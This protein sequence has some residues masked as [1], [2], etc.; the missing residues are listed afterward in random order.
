[1]LAYCR[2]TINKERLTSFSILI[3]AVIWSVFAGLKT[4][5]T[6]LYGDMTHYDHIAIAILGHHVYS[7]WG[8]DPDAQITPGYPLFLS[9]CYLIANL[10]YPNHPFQLGITV[11]FQSILSGV[12]VYL[13]YQL[14][15]QCT[16][17]LLSAF[18]AL[19]YS[20]YPPSVFAP[21]MILTETLYTFLLLLFLYTFFIAIQKQ[22]MTRWLICGLT[23]GLCCT[24]RPS[25]FPFL[26]APM[27]Y[28]TY[29]WLNRRKRRTSRIKSTILH[30][31]A[32]AAGFIFPL[33]PWW[34]RNI[35]AFHQLILTDMDASNPLL[36]GTDPTFQA[37]SMLGSGLDSKGQMILA[38]HR[39]FYYFSNEFWTYLWWY[40]GEKLGLLF[41]TPW[42][43]LVA[44]G[45]YSGW[46][47][48]VLFCLHLHFPFV[49]LG[50][51]GLTLGINH[52]T[53]R[54]VSWFT[55]SLILLL[56]PFIPL[57]RYAFPT[58]PF[59]FIGTAY[60]VHWIYAQLFEIRA[61]STTYA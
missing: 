59:F 5:M 21:T 14:S 36:F 28:V 10:F 19:A 49:I 26:V 1:M 22:T 8:F 12:S 13:V 44:P 31:T 34:I 16:G 48:F 54:Y 24:V 11:A 7:Y 27:V 42:F 45:D 25:V 58:M 46:I 55:F 20:L 43:H 50:G 32:Y 61:R 9:L 6:Q 17:C 18:A 60:L 57:P 23:I 40:T 56:L 29:Q 33:V 3:L 35:R 37:D 53:M 51:I 38:L 30:Y 52:P 41:S 39:I 2:K 4:P 47:A 15:R